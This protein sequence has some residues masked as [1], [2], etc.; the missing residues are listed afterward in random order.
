LPAFIISVN[1]Q[2]VDAPNPVGSPRKLSDNL[3]HFVAG[4]TNGGVFVGKDAIVVI[5]T[6]YEAEGS[7]NNL[8]LYNKI[9]EFADSPIKYVINTHSHGDHSGGNE[10]FSDRGRPLLLTKTRS[11][12]PTQIIHST[13]K[14]Y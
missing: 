6:T 1:S 13:L 12:V 7:T 2:A 3:H 9:D 14:L 4:I 10:I 8:D 11:S 5:D